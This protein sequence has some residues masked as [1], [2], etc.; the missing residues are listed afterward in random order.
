[1]THHPHLAEALIRDAKDCG[2]KYAH[3]GQHSY[4]AEA[5]YLSGTVRSLCAELNEFHGI[6]ARARP[7][8]R[9]G[10]FEWL[11]QTFQV[12]YQRDGSDTSFLA[13]LINGA[14]LDAEDVIDGDT[15]ETWREEMVEA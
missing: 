12:E 14:W 13:V 1:M 7:G 6:G 8:C 3:A 15:L 2:A 4:A 5:G 9:I 10:E 11:G